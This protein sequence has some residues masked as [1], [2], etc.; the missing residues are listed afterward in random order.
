MDTKGRMMMAQSLGIKGNIRTDKTNTKLRCEEGEIGYAIKWHYKTNFSGNNKYL[1][2]GKELGDRYK[3]NQS[4]ADKRIDVDDRVIYMKKDSPHFGQEAKVIEV[5]RPGDELSGLQ[6]GMMNT[7]FDTR[8]KIKFIRGTRSGFGQ[9]KNFI[10]VKNPEELKKIPNHVTYI[11]INWWKE[12]FNKIVKEE[13]KKEKRLIK[14]EEKEKIKAKVKNIYNLLFNEQEYTALKTKLSTNKLDLVNNLIKIIKDELDKRNDAKDELKSRFEIHLTKI[15]K[16]SKLKNDV[17]KLLISIDET[18]YADRLK[19]DRIYILVSNEGAL[20]LKKKLE[21]KKTIEEMI[22]NKATKNKD[23]EDARSLAGDSSKKD[24]KKELLSFQ[25]EFLEKKLNR[26]LIILLPQDTNF[27]PEQV[28]GIHGGPNVKSRDM[29]N[30]IRPDKSLPFV[31]G[32]V[33]IVGDIEPK[34]NK[35]AEKDA[36]NAGQS[37]AAEQMLDKVGNEYYNVNQEVFI[38]LRKFNKSLAGDL[39]QNAD[40]WLGC[41]KHKREI[42][43]IFSDVLKQGKDALNNAP[44]AA[45]GEISLNKLKNWDS[46]RDWDIEDDLDVKFS[47]LDKVMVQKEDWDKPYKATIQRINKNDTYDVEM[48]PKGDYRI[49]GQWIKNVLVE[50]IFPISNPQGGGRKKRK[51][52]KRRKRK[53]RRKSRKKIK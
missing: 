18:E 36:K 50:N 13:R 12:Y 47:R 34:L 10:V 26:E 39:V 8:Y 40:Y 37:A 41:G 52:R 23:I 19:K 46:W 21:R 15:S 27:V 17:I 42:K 3:Q 48:D 51:T 11:C 2:R 45:A 22:V 28:L 7:S 14:K 30:M 35:K 53:R 49:P 6:S 5:V 24:K 32:S 29:N 9:T 16:L 20:R 38:L 25:D 44:G 31:I 4:A 33:N 1:F 43:K